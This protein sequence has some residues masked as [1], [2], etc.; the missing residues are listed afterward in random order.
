MMSQNLQEDRDRQGNENAYRATLR[1]ELDVNE[2]HRKVDHLAT[3]QLNLVAELHRIQF[4]AI[5]SILQQR[6]AAPSSPVQTNYSVDAV[7]QK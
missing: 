1:T 7:P 4:D 5:Q 3:R 6:A 2:L